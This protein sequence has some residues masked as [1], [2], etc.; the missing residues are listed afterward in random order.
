MI[1]NDA[2]DACRQISYKARLGGLWIGQIGAKWEK[3]AIEKRF[4]WKSSFMVQHLSV[5]S[6]KNSLKKFVS[7]TVFEILAFL[8]FFEKFL[9]RK[10]SIGNKAFLFTL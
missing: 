3:G 4:F 1:M 8:G 2:D 7:L 6:L 9:F 10:V 5:N